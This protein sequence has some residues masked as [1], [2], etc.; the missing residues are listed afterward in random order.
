MKAVALAAD[1]DGDDG[2]DGGSRKINGDGD[3]STECSAGEKATAMAAAT[4]VE[5]SGDRVD[6]DGEV[7]FVQEGDRGGGSSR[8][9]RWQEVACNFQTA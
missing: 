4:E 5:A 8:P 9:S 1:N 6:E 3:A 2:Q 7:R